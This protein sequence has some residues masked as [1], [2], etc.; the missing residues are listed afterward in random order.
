[1]TASELET[2]VKSLAGYN[3]LV[4]E[5]E[6]FLAQDLCTTLQRC[7]AR[8]IGPVSSSS[9]A[10]QLLSQDQPDCVLLDINLNG[11]DAFGLARELRNAG[12][13]TV[14][15]TGYDFSFIPAGLRE[16]A[17]VQKPLQT[18]ALVRAVR[19]K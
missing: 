19:A 10:R 16:I 15:T 12:I 3:I 11:Q 4:V 17:C 8:V 2:G 18:D 9:S 1:M 6:Y 13:H 7:G 14:F 5:D